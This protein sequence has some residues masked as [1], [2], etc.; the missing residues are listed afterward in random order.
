MVNHDH[1]VGSQEIIV[2]ESWRREGEGQ[3]QLVLQLHVGIEYSIGDH[4]TEESLTQEV[5]V[6]VGWIHLGTRSQQQ[7]N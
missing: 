5:D 3:R 2:Q 6:A 4:R 1:V 7:L